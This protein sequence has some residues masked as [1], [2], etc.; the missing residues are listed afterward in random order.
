M[1]VTELAMAK[2]LLS[3]VALS[4]MDW[5]RVRLGSKTQSAGASTTKEPSEL[6][7]RSMR[8][9]VSGRF[10]GMI[11]WAQYWI[12]PPRRA[13]TGT[14]SEKPSGPMSGQKV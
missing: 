6:F 11:A 13:V 5:L 12:R 7:T 3:A 1:P 10:P 2:E 9:A 14:S 8:S 4:S